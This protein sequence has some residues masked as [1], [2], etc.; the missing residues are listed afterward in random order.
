MISTIYIIGAII[1][2]IILA[3]MFREEFTDSTSEY[4]A[5]VCLGA[6]VWPVTIIWMISAWIEW[7]RG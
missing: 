1:T 3:V 5:M 7:R 6:L 4:L 2:L